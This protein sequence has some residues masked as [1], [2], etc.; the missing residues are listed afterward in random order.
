MATKREPEVSLVAVDALDVVPKV[1]KIDTGYVTRERL[2][3]V[4]EEQNLLSEFVQK[5]L[6]EGYHYGLHPGTQTKVLKKPGAEELCRLY[7]LQPSYDILTGPTPEDVAAGRIYYR[8]RC[9][10]SNRIGAWEGLASCSSMESKYRWRWVFESDIPPGLEPEDLVQKQIYSKKKG[11]NYTMY[12]VPNDEAAD[13]DNTI[14]KMGKKRAYVDATITATHTSHL[15]TQDIIEDDSE[16]DDGSSSH[17][18]SGVGD[19]ETKAT[20]DDGQVR[21]LKA[22]MSGYKKTAASFQKK[23]AIDVEHLPH[24]LY[25]EAVRWASDKDAD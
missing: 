8:I 7:K 6:K 21:M 14:L 17:D 3:Q 23:F 10:L 19:Y 9:T 12:R 18:G 15:F 22:I 11:R 16:I 4:L 1:D 2:A 25:E 20:I 24:N 13:L 5:A